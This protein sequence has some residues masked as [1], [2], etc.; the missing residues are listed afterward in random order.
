MI[1]AVFDTETTG[2]PN[3]RTIT[4][5]TLPLW[6]YIVQLSYII[7]DTEKCNILTMQDKFVRIP[8]EIVMDEVV[9]KIHGISNEQAHSNNA[10]NIDI[11]LALQNFY[12]DLCRN[13]VT[14]LVGHNISFDL[15]MI[16]VELA[17]LEQLE[18]CD[19][20]DATRMT[21]QFLTAL[22][23]NKFQSYCT[24]MNSIKVCKLPR[25][26]PRT[27]YNHESE[28]ATSAATASASSSSQ[29]TSTVA[30]NRRQSVSY[31]YPKL[32]ELHYH[33]YKSVPSNLHNSMV[34]VL[35][36][37]RCFYHLQ[38]NIDLL[39]LDSNLNDIMESTCAF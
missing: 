39:A 1:V 25:S 3:A 20:N 10:T 12:D 36:T 21:K 30:S 37:L 8:D 5:E 28:F 34:D 22:H 6:P 32:S 31:K 35:T 7:Y 14:M 18:S 9:V 19:A 17:R 15:S 33:F 24:M 38:N 27:M 13:N 4:K 23:E 16:N 11:F 26:P 2:L 29:S